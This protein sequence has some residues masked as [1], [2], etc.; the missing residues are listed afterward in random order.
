MELKAKRKRVFTI[1]GLVIVAALMVWGIVSHQRNAQLTAGVTIQVT[2]EDSIVT[3]NGKKVPTN[4]I[5][6]VKVKPGTYK[7]VA[8]R[9][10]FADYTQTLTLKKGQTTYFGAMLISNDSSTANW[11]AN[12]PADQKQVETISGKLFNQSAQNE[13]AQTP[14]IQYLPFI[15][16]QYRIDYGVSVAHP[17]DPNAVGIYITYYSPQGLDQA[18]AWI[19]FKGYDP[20]K[21]ELIEKA[22]PSPF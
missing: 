6:P 9:K 1:L 8:S 14:L 5:E 7:A 15:D 18:L 13:L 3:L 2:P 10:G 4:N 16:L 12:H 11:Y 20:S 21:L 17:N 22:A 19:K